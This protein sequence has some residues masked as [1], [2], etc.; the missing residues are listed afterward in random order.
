MSKIKVGEIIIAKN[1][2]KVHGV[3]G[4]FDEACKRLKKRYSEAL[5]YPVN[6]EADFRI[7][8]N[9]ER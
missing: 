2:R 4:A 5:G 1:C 3:S 9:V 6:K 7:I 8:M